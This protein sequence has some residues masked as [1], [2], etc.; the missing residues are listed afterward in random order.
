MASRL[1]KDVF[2]NIEQYH[3]GADYMDEPM[4]IRLWWD[5]PNAFH[6]II[7]KGNIIEG[8]EAKE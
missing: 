3:T 1:S 6:P 4:M 7:A 5:E 8:I 2:G